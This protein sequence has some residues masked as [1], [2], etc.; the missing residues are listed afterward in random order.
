MHDYFPLPFDILSAHV[1]LALKLLHAFPRRM[2]LRI[3]MSNL[4]LKKIHG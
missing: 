1:Q 2:I 4:L 3:E